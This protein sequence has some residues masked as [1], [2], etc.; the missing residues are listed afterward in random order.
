MKNK[1][2]TH[3]FIL[4]VYG[5]TGVGKTDM[6]LSIAAGIPSEI[7]NMDMGQFY[8]PLSIGTA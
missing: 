5:P 8:A 6:A 4:I 3:P 2:A 1:I 7:I